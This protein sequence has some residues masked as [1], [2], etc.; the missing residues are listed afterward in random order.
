MCVKDNLLP[1]GI[2][3]YA[4][5][6]V[7]WST[8]AMGKDRTIWGANAQEFIPER[9]LEGESGIKPNQFKFNSFHG[10]PRLWYV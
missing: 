7:A 2:P 10:G 4:G 5:D 9:F 3:I 6:W 8:W 1:N